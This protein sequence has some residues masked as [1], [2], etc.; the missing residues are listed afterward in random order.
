M[1]KF[2]KIPEKSIILLH[3]C[4]H[5]PTGV[6]P[7]PEQWQELSQVI[8]SR[9]LYVFFDMAYQGFAS[10]VFIFAPDHF[11]CSISFFTGNVDGDAF[12]VRQFLKDGHNLCLS[13]SYAKNMGLYGERAGA[14]TVVCQDKEEAARVN[15]QIKILI[16]PLYSNPPIHGAR[17]VTEILSNQVNL[18]NGH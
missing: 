1:D 9:N 11:Q 15:S 2:Q 8:K 17:I 10:G 13:Q 18:Y 16:R 14:F 3:A 12:A 4:A 7:K 5:N 6:D